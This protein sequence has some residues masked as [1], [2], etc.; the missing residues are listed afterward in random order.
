MIM[1]ST[2]KS[3]QRG[4]KTAWLTWLQDTIF[5]V[6]INIVCLII[7]KWWGSNNPQIGEI[8]A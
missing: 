3:F 4:D 1:E 7:G 8:M 2:L 5:Q 6:T